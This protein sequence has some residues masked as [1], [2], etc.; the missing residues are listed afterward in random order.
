MCLNIVCHQHYENSLGISERDLVRGVL[1]P[2]TACEW[3][4]ERIS[5]C[6]LGGEN[7]SVLSDRL[8]NKRIVTRGST[9]S[10]ALNTQG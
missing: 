4:A 10:K 8:T 2:R 3:E 7:G 9:S 1:D 6:K 5:T